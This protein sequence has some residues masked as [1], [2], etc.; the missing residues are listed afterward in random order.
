MTIDNRLWAIITAF[1]CVLLLG[2]GWFVGVE[3]RL[4]AAD[5]ANEQRQTVE[6]QNTLA[7]A[8]VARLQEAEGNRDALDAQLAEL[9][10]AV[11]PGVDGSGFLATLDQLVAAHGVVLASVALS[12]PL[13]YVPP[14][15]GDFSPLTDASITSENFV[16]VPVEV[17]VGGTNEQV[18]A[19]LASLQSQK[20][21]ILIN[22]VARVRDEA[23]AD[24][25]GL[26]VSGY[27]FVLRDPAA[28]AA[29]D[30]ADADE[31]APATETAAG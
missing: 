10:A 18:L 14:A 4:A 19:F 26:A 29:A 5:R 22:E 6:A 2:A 21:L 17:A 16:L 12:D 25:Y 11:P 7:R 20:R 8:E 27:I 31:E 3:P 23:N 24:L 1:V 30:A 15:E 13:A 9:R 28:E